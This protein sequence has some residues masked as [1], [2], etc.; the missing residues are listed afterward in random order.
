MISPY[1]VDTGKTFLKKAF[2]DGEKATKT[3]IF[4]EIYHTF[5]CTSTANLL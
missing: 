4:D 2:L 5:D 3:P 1:A